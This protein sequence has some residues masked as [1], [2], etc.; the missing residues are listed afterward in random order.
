M[1]TVAE[2][3]L[4]QPAAT[5]GVVTPL[6][7]GSGTWRWVVEL[8]DP[9]AG[10][11]IVWH[12]IT[13]YWAGHDHQ[14]GAD[15]HAG[16]FRSDVVTVD[17]ATE[18]D[19]LA[20][21]NEDTSATFGTHVAL[22][23][24]LFIRAGL[25]RVVAGTV[26]EWNPRFTVRVESWSDASYAR[27]Q[28]RRHTVTGRGTMT[29]LVNVPIVA[30]LEDN[31]Y[32]RVQH[33]LTQ[34]AWPY[35]SAIFGAI[36]TSGAADILTLPDAAETDDAAQAL[37]AALDP[38]GMVWWTD[39]VGRL[40]ARPQP[41]D[42]FHADAFTAGATGTPFVDADPVIFS[43]NAELDGRVAYAADDNL[44]P[45][46][47]EDTELY[48]V[49]HVR[50]TDPGGSYDTDD[51]VSIQRYGRKSRL[52]SWQAAND[53]AADDTLTRLAYASKQATPLTTTADLPGFFPAAARLEYLDP[54]QIN[55]QTAAGRVVVTADGRARQLTERISPR[56]R[57]A[58]G[59]V[60]LNW[61]IVVT[62]DVDTF[63][64]AAELLPVENL[65]VDSLSYDDVTVDW[66][67]PAQTIPPTETWVR[68][69]QESN[70]WIELGYPITAFAW[71]A[72]QPETTYDAEVRLVRRVDG[73][74]TNVSPVRSVEFTTLAAPTADVD[75]DGDGG[76]VITLPD[77]D[78]PVDCVIDWELSSSDDGTTWSLVDSGTA[79][80]G[81]IIPIDSSA[82][83]PSLTYR[84]CVTEV[85]DD[86][87][88]TEYCTIP[89][90]SA[91]ITSPA[92]TALDPPYDDAS[93]IAYIPEACPPNLVKEA[94][95]GFAGAHGPA[96]GG[97]FAVDPDDI[98]L[99]SD[100]A[101]GGIIAFG[102]AP[103]LAYTGAATIG[104]RV[105]VQNGAD[106]RLFS[107]AGLRL[108]CVDGTTGW[109]PRAS[110]TTIN[111][112]E[113]T[114]TDPT[115]RALITPH[116]L[117]A[118]YDD[119]T[120]ELELFVDGT[121]V[122]SDTVDE[123]GAR[124]NAGD[125]WYVGAPAASWITDCAVWSTVLSF[126]PANG[127]LYDAITALSP[128][129]YWTL[130][131]GDLN[132][133]G[134]LGIDLTNPSTGISFD[135]TG[136]DGDY[137]SSGGSNANLQAADDIGYEPQN[138]GG[139]TV[140]MLLK[141]DD[142][143]TGLQ[144]PIGKWTASAGSWGCFANNSTG[145][146]IARA[147]TSAG[148]NARQ[149]SQSPAWTPDTNWHVISLIYSGSP[150]G[151]PYMRVDGTEYSSAGTSGTG[152]A[153]SNSSVQLR[154][155]SQSATNGSAVSL[156]HVA[157]FAGQ[158]SSSDLAS[159]EAAAALDGF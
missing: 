35:G 65:A 68:I 7:S 69:P 158:L 111:G 80:G 16:R 121:S 84:V 6:V 115:E 53:T 116:Q 14:R 94:I 39:R 97:F 12:D 52:V 124:A 55:A 45:F 154:L 66:T 58:A 146:L 42:T 75:T 118:T 113:V 17:L 64:T 40:V 36:L 156:A 85:C 159:I 5:A 74:V 63:G 47:L 129:S 20:P 23:A 59:V 15:E 152:T 86:V 18:A 33:V 78:D 120:G 51:P 11:S 61:E 108:D 157:I 140:V 49:N 99:A 100:T 101:A 67:N 8:A 131:D 43:Y 95:S 134:S 126:V 70:L 122:G 25:I 41:G 96:W 10:T 137:P 83:D 13:D 112:D 29:D 22:G 44:T 37:D 9:D 81:A 125:Y 88:G 54:V 102:N 142:T 77:V 38:A 110:V 72:L 139:L 62:V 155:F 89:D 138:A 2:L 1:T 48:V 32:D 27:G 34:S 105:S 82:L 107:I 19:R 73:L 136:P 143:T 106:Q 46:G 132:D 87:P 135:T 144:Y 145:Q 57:S 128:L 30:D 50:V 91:C 4:E 117:F 133:Y 151:F 148:A 141:P 28:I 90:V 147:T 150:T 92:Y 114:V 31:W 103:N 21:W 60:G 130:R 56:S 76:F 71:L 127:Y 153:D 24:G 119:D 109:Y 123:P 26:V 93:L 149:R 79:A 3:M 98:A 104:C